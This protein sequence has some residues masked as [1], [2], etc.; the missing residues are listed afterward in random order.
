[1]RLG[2]TLV[3]AARGSSPLTER[4][5]DDRPLDQAGGYDV[6]LAAP[7]LIPLGAAEPNRAT[8]RR[9]RAAAPLAPRSRATDPALGYAPLAQPALRE[10][11]MGVFRKSRLPGSARHA[12][13][14]A[15]GADRPSPRSPPSDRAPSTPGSPTPVPPRTAANPS[16]P[17]SPG[18]GTGP[19]P[20]PPTT[21][22]SSPSP[23]PSSCAPPL[24][25][26]LKATPATYGNVGVHPLF[27][28]TPIGR[29]VPLAPPARRRP[30]PAE[31]RDRLA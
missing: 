20:V 22:P 25:H 19:A 9:P 15:A 26:A 6:Q 5:D 16:S 18:Q 8:A 21:A 28:L 13:S 30:A 27:T 29:P 4:F 23:S 12:R 1:M 24:V 14:R 3:T 17:S 10:C 7:A 11:G 31:R 2:V